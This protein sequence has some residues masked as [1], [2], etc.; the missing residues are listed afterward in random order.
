MPHR[1]HPYQ[2]V[3]ARTR[4]VDRPV[5][6]LAYDCAKLI[7]VRHEGRHPIPQ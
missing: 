4:T 6:P 3:L 2:P 5:S 7:F 1:T